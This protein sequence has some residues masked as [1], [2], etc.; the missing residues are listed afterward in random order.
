M[1]AAS[2]GQRLAPLEGGR[3]AATGR[4]QATELR[5]ENEVRA[6]IVLDG[7]GAGG[8]CK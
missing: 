6:Q 4:E 8:V 7:G 3:S 2:F 1:A 5:Q